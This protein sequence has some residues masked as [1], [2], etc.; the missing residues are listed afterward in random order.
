MNVPLITNISDTAR[1]VAVYRAWESARADAL[2]LDPFADRLAGPRG[3]AIATMMPRQA[4]SGWPLVVRTKLIDD[5]VLACV[6]EGCGCV[7]NLA[8]GFDTRPYRLALPATLQWIEADLPA[9]IEEKQRLLAGAQPLCRLS[10]E[11]VDLTDA[12]AR[13]AF[14]DQ[15][16]AQ[17]IKVLVITE[18]LLIYLEEAVVRALA[19]DLAA[20]SQ[21]HWWILD[22]AGPGLL[23]MMQRRMGSQL[24][25]APM[26]FAPPSGVGFFESYGW[27]APDIHSLFRAAAR[28]RRL[29]P[30]LWP[31]A[32]FPD[33]DPRRP[34]AARWSAVV[35]LSR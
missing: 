33:P 1:W 19:T 30:L 12:A 15:L 13:G 32:M 31:L 22:L 21:L 6:A 28:L 34:G 4:R 18:G 16:Q 20:R 23:R 26:K 2:F 9:M 10:R 3:R 11:A 27:R 5:L 14:L 17:P 29:P 25:L 24:A 7:A 8:A 35:R